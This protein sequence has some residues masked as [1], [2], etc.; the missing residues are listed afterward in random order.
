MDQPWRTIPPISRARQA[1]FTNPSLATHH[2]ALASS[3]RLAALA[4]SGAPR[5]YRS[6]AGSLSITC[7]TA[8]FAT[9]GS[10][11]SRQR[12]GSPPGRAKPGHQVLSQGKVARGVMEPCRTS[13][14]AQLVNSRIR[15]WFRRRPRAALSGLAGSTEVPLTD[16]ALS[17]RRPPSPRR[18]PSKKAKSSPRTGKRSST[19]HRPTSAFPRIPR[20]PGH[21]PPTPISS[22][23][24]VAPRLS[25]RRKSRV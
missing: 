18:R 13:Y 22:L 3:S 5:R 1:C 2:Q 4:A 15:C 8:L 16:A 21:K 7:Q 23:R 12:Q 17:L 19:S 6:A 24:T 11:T 9:S 10:T 14:I 25:L 20:Q